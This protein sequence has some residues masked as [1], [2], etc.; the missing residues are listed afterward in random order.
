MCRVNCDGEQVTEFCSLT[1]ADPETAVHVLEAMGGNLDQAVN[2]FFETGGAGFGRQ[3][4]ASSAATGA[5]TRC[6]VKSAVAIHSYCLDG[7]GVA[8][9]C[10]G[11]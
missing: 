1:G 2:L 3:N 5:S 8:Q 4:S 6:V 7:Y 9:T 11:P 10:S